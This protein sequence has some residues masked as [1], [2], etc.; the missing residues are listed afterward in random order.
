MRCPCDEDVLCGVAHSQSTLA[1]DVGLTG[2]EPRLAALPLDW[3]FVLWQ[4]ALMLGMLLVPSAATGIILSSVM[5]ILWKRK[6][7]W[8]EAV[9]AMFVVACVLASSRAG[10]MQYWKSLRL[11][12]AA[13]IFVEALRAFREMPTMNRRSSVG[14]VLM[15]VLCTGMPAVFS[16]YVAEGIEVSILLS[17]MWWAML[18]LGRIHHRGDATQR[19]IT[20]MH[21]G[22]LVALVSLFVR[23]WNFELGH[24]NGRF[25]GIFGN[26]NEF[27]H[28]WLGIGVLGL[29]GS[30]NLKNV[31][32][33]FLLAATVLFYYW[34]GT[35]GA[36][37][38]F[39][40]SV[41]GWLSLHI[42][43]SF[44]SQMTKVLLA[45][46]VI[47]AM[48]TVSTN[49]LLDV[50]PD[51]VMRQESFGEGGGRLLAWEHAW[52]QI[53]EQ[54]WVGAGGGAEERYFTSN[55]RYFANQNHQ[56]LSHNSWL[57]FAMNFG[58]P[59]TLVLFFMLLWRLGLMQRSLF[60]MGSLPLIFSFT[61]EGWLTAPMSASSPML[62]FV[63]GLLA[64]VMDAR[65]EASQT[66]D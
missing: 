2:I 39:V 24:L 62:F 49:V 31:R 52:H 35:R 65:G 15:M 57:A 56:G 6:A 20:L 23:F 50:L 7:G 63:G 1:G 59:A 45:G 40:L 55:Y 64:S 37:A 36:L 43:Q 4:G 13:L 16:E 44:A 53:I 29:L 9:V 51:R 41:G 5:L 30:E 48:T 17:F 61:V 47:L 3:T 21:V 22:M 10:G 25:R 66:P 27:S 54:P 32:T 33:F 42:P 18:V 11:V 46:A 14:F 26:P 12:F 8:R 19:F 60:I 58:I 38:A 34:S 28:W